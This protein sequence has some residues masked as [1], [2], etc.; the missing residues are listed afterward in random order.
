MHRGRFGY[1]VVVDGASLGLDA[2]WSEA[3]G[4]AKQIASLR[5]PGDGRG[6]GRCSHRG[7]SDCFTAGH[8]LE[9]IDEY[10]GPIP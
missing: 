5:P 7:S 2:S 8:C 6:Y 3:D 4:L 1:D 9:P 10:L